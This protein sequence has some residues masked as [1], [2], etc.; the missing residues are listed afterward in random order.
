MRTCKPPVLEAPSGSLWRS[1]GRLWGRS[2]FAD[3]VWKP[4]PVELPVLPCPAEASTSEG[5][6]GGLR[7]DWSLRTGCRPY[8]NSE[9]G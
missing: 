5:R 1:R 3:A 8:G 2:G 9:V 7:T 6:P 4:Y